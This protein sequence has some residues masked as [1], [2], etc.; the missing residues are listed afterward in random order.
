MGLS[1]AIITCVYNI[2]SVH[3]VSCSC[4]M[5]TWNS[6]TD[7]VPQTIFS[8]ICPSH[9]SG[10]E[11]GSMWANWS[12]SRNSQTQACHRTGLKWML[13]TSSRFA[14]HGFP[15]CCS[16]QDNHMHFVLSPLTPSSW[17]ALPSS[18]LTC[19][20]GPFRGPIHSYLPHQ[21]VGCTH[22][23]GLSCLFPD[24]SPVPNTVPDT[25]STLF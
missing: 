19:F 11:P 12:R 4:P 7:S 25:W 1:A 22:A 13:E 14:T 17:R 6:C 3:V 5:F 21:T 24:V 15:L 9:V 10:S 16:C 8:S 23:Q 18:D 20:A 2:P